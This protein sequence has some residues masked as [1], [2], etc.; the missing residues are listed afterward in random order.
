MRKSYS[1][2]KHIKQ[3]NIILEQRRMLI[4]EQSTKNEEVKNLTVND[5]NSLSV[6][7]SDNGIPGMIKSGIITYKDG[8]GNS[9][10][11][12]LT[13]IKGSKYV[14]LQG[15]INVDVNSTLFGFLNQY[16]LT[17]TTSPDK[18]ITDGTQIENIINNSS[19][20]FVQFVNPANEEETIL[21][22]KTKSGTYEML[23]L[24]IFNK[25]L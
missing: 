19:D 25:K 12:D 2:I 4:N 24:N 13:P 18:L 14:A 1:K 9:T 17:L 11:L 3:S 15:N 22:I 8:D 5:I 21:F 10:N 20:K 7:P 6:T 16:T 23:Y